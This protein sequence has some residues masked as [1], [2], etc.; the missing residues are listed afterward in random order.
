MKVKRLKEILNQL[1]DEVE[2]MIRNTVNPCGNIQDLDQVE[3]STYQSFGNT[4]PCL[5]LNTLNAKEIE[6]DENGEL[7]DVIGL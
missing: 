4:Y 5:I 3:V 1:D 7:L 2:I 6:E